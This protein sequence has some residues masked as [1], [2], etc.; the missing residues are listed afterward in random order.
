MV[1]KEEN[2]M[3]VRNAGFRVRLRAFRQDEAGQAL[4]EVALSAPLLLL[5]LLGAAEFARVAY[6]AIEV[7]NAASAAALYAASSHGNAGN[8]TNISAMALNDAANLG[9]GTGG[10]VTVT[11]IST[12]CSCAN[13]SYTPSSC[14]DNNTCPKN[15]TAMVET[16][17][18]NTQVTYKPLISYIGL[19]NSGWFSGPGSF[20]LKGQAVQ[21]VSNQ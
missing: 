13:S 17:T 10:A 11:N 20:T 1:E 7:S 4:V 2:S 19:G 3:T 12:S 6:A 18:V 8:T 21:T 14:S 16:I 15:G 5:L 9:A